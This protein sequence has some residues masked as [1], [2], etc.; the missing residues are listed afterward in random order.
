M[1]RLESLFPS[2]SLSHLRELIERWPAFRPL[3]EHLF[4]IYA[5]VDAD[6]IQQ[7]LRWRLAK[8][9][10][11]HARSAFYEAVEA[12]FIIPIAPPYLK[13]EI[14]KHLERIASETGAS[15]VEVRSEWENIQGQ[16]AFYQPRP[17]DTD[18]IEVADEND[19]PYKQAADEL[20]LPVYSEDRHFGRM[21][22][23]VIR[24]CLDLTAREYVRAASVTVG[25]TYH[26]TLTVVVAVQGLI[27]F[28]RL[29]KSLFSLF[30]RLPT[31]VQVGITG[32]V[33]GLLIHPKS[34][35][36]L[37]AGIKAAYKAASEMKPQ[38]MSALAGLIDEF[39]AAFVALQK[40]REELRSS[41][42]ARRPRSVL[43]HARTV[44]VTSKGPLSIDELEHRIK[45]QGYASRAQD[46]KGYLRR[47]LRKS[48]QFFEVNPGIWAL[49]AV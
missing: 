25:T 22:V 37:I 20:G 12:R 4:Q 27:G 44:F 9:R 33:A 48:G 32:V 5:I 8:R 35:A 24:I 1:G 18:R 23:P 26:S 43:M 11:P 31:V 3:L 10:N 34:G 6:K 15:V 49:R 19:L 2:G 46:F 39:G 38:A 40:A 13:V 14:E 42:P 28:C 47:V 17:T 7:E 21:N 29:L 16:I 45:T 30:G 41:L 36:K